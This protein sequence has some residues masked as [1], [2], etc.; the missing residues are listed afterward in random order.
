MKTITVKK[1][2][3]A[4]GK[5]F[6]FRYAAGTAEDPKAGR[7]EVGA[8]PVK[9]DLTTEAAQKASLLKTILAYIA[10]GFLSLVEDVPEPEQEATEQPARRGRKKAEEPVEE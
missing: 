9:V 8:S 7:V 10:G 6:G 5:V 3:L 1:G 2:P 4:S